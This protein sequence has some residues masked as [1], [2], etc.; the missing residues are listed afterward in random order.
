M[1]LLHDRFAA[2]SDKTDDEETRDQHAPFGGLG[3]SM[4]A[5]AATRALE[6]IRPARV[7]R[8]ELRETGFMVPPVLLGTVRG[9]EASEHPHVSGR[10]WLTASLTEVV[11]HPK[12]TS[13][14]E[15]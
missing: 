11:I 14:V 15:P 2:P 8:T 1:R 13:A 9:L 7:E 10:L 5:P 3:A 12:H 4:S 6:P